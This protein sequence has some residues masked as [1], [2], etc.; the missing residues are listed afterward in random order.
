[1]HVENP[2][3]GSTS[4]EDV[5]RMSTIDP[6]RQIKEAAARQPGLIRAPKA[7]TTASVLR[8]D[9]GDF[10]LLDSAGARYPG[11][12]LLAAEM[13]IRERRSRVGT[14]MA[15]PLWDWKCFL[16]TGAVASPSRAHL[17]TVRSLNESHL[18]DPKGS[19]VRNNTTRTR[20]H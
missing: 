17:G 10:G 15:G 7:E 1:M 2:G 20:R 16:L 9:K 6:A 3:V 12:S 18:R 19:W 8:L 11:K 14:S 5:I 13:T 4:L